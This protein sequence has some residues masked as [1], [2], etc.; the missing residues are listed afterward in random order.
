MAELALEEDL[1]DESAFHSQQA[2]EKSLKAIVALL[3]KRPPKTHDIDVILQSLRDLGV[4]CP[5][6]DVSSL[7]AYAVESRYPGPPIVEEEAKEALNIA[8][9]IYNWSKTFFKKRNIDC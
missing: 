1:F 8:K 6:E 5:Y 3:G 2:A 4:E 9:R 7:T